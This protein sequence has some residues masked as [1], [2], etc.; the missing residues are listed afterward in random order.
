M[1][2]I[3][4]IIAVEDGSLTAEQFHEYAQGFVDRG[5][6]RSLQGS[7]QR[8]VLRWAEQGLVTIN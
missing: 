6:W 5:L 1:D 3:D 2:D 4:F 7:W 8:G